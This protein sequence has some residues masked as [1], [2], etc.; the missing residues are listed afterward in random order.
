MIIGYG[1]DVMKPSRIQ[2]AIKSF[3]EVFMNRIYTH[4]HLAQIRTSGIWVPEISATSIEDLKESI[5]KH[6]FEREEHYV[7]LPSFLFGN[8]GY[9]IGL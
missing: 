7:T 2:D 4:S 6:D 1:I 3:K 5:E 9:K 8:F